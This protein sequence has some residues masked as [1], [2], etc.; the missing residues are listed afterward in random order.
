MLSAL[1]P[2]VTTL[3]SVLRSRAA[4]HVEILALRHQIGV[5]RRAAKK[6]ARAASG[7]MGYEAAL[8]GYLAPT[9]SSLQELA[10]YGVRQPDSA[11]GDGTGRSTSR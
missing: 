10:R 7:R 9:S 8:H 5:L 11:A 6:S 1:S 3:F 4:L 2:F